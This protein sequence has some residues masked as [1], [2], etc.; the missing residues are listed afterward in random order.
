MRHYG[1]LFSHFGLYCI[2]F[3]RVDKASLPVKID[4]G[5]PRLP[6]IIVLDAPPDN[7][8]RQNS[9][10]VNTNQA[11]KFTPSPLPAL[12]A[13]QYTTS[14][15]SA[16]RLLNPTHN[17]AQLARLH[18]NRY[19]LRLQNFKDGIS[20]FL[21]RAFLDMKSTGKHLGDARQLGDVNDG[22]VRDVANVHF[23]REWH[24]VML[25][26][27][28]D[29]DIFKNDH[30][31]VLFLEDGAV[32]N[33]HE[34]LLVALCEEQQGVGVSLRCI[35]ES[36]LYAPRLPLDQNLTMNWHQMKER[37]PWARACASSEVE[38]ARKQTGDRV[39]GIER[40]QVAFRRISSSTTAIRGNCRRPMRSITCIPD[41][42]FGYITKFTIDN[43]TLSGLSYQ[44][45]AKGYIVVFANNVE[46]LIT[47]V[48]PHP[49]LA[50][51]ENTHV[52]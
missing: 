37:Q 52:S 28:V 2:D 35:H 34:I 49:L 22:V 20:H 1:D 39:Y 7:S 42:S 47:T 50:A 11:E 18:D 45:Y 51:I 14:H 44:K 36:G 38:R 41:S 30:L 19:S 43:K 10:A 33:V 40:M 6:L 5:H 26:D 24:K 46:D 3:G 29:V 15:S 13:A 23:A 9:T 31:I 32:D 21:G 25:T 4:K 16:P 17:H 12:K 27:L 48:L 8:G